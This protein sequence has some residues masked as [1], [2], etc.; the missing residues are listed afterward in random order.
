MSEGWG[1]VAIACGVAGGGKGATR[2]TAL[3]LSETVRGPW[4][5]RLAGRRPA[6]AQ[7]STTIVYHLAGCR[8]TLY[9]SYDAE[10]G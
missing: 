7:V 5:G 10:M 6:A 8:I 2:S 4:R 1:G 9:V 3:I